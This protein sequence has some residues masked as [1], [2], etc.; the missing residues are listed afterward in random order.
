MNPEKNNRSPSPPSPASQPPPPIVF[1]KEVTG[2]VFNFGPQQGIVSTGDHAVNIQMPKPPPEGTEPKPPAGE[3]AAPNFQSEQELEVFLRNW[4]LNQWKSSASGG[5]GRSGNVLIRTRWQGRPALLKIS[6][7]GAGLRA[8][9]AHL[10]DLR[11]LGVGLSVARLFARAE[12]A[13][14][15]DRWMGYLIEPVG[16]MSL[17]DY[18]FTG[19]PSPQRFLASLG[20]GLTGLYGRTARPTTRDFV[21]EYLKSIRDSLEKARGYASFAGLAAHFDG[22][23]QIKRT[24]FAGPAALLT[25]L[26]ARLRQGDPALR[27][28]NPACDCHVHGD[29]HFENVRID[30][31]EAGLGLHWLIDPK[32][33][34]RGDYV[35]D[36]AKLL[37][38]LTGHA[39][40]D[41]GE[42]E[43]GDPRL[44]WT[45]AAGGQID[46]NCILTP[47][48]V[49]GWREG[50]AAI[51][52]LARDLAP[53]LEHAADTGANGNHQTFLQM[54]QRLLLVLA[55]HYFSALRFFLEREAQWLLFARGTQ[56]LAMFQA[57]LE[58]RPGQEWSPFE[59]CSTDAWLER[60]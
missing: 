5:T 49:E 44:K 32:E 22:E 53:R 26:E 55:R 35:Y 57:A 6:A 16:E 23:L 56:F 11:R 54:Q 19:T 10:E 50:L 7:D 42:H 18:L 15:D 51:E 59:V 45:T 9:A 24:A 52:S 47:R 17:R 48:Q 43:N 40:A 8:E 41:I 12:A 14:G 25:G 21:A 34:D 28:L 2:A 36:L 38:S 46:F 39:H 13:E 33:F 1:E 31:A 3:A 58:N 60:L 27:A 29:L 20:T 37:T 4:V 30:P